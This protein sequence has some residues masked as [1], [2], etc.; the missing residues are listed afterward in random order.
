[1]NSEIINKLSLRDSGWENPVGMIQQ[2]SGNL[3]PESGKDAKRLL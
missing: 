3:F 1:M 2:E